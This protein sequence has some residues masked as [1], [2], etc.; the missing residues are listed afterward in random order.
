MQNNWREYTLDDLCFKITDGSHQSPKAFEG[1]IPMYSVKD[2]NDHG[3][4]RSG[5]K[6]I[7]EQDYAKLLAQGCQPEVSDILIAKDGSVM[8][9]V[10]KVDTIEKC[11]LLSS[12]AILRPKTDLVDPDFLVFSILNP[13]V[14]NNILS[15]YVSGSGVPRIVLKDFKKVVVRVPNLAIQKDI[16]KVI[17][18][19]NQKI[20]LN[21]QTNQTLEQ[22]AQ[23]L[24][25]SWFVDFD[26]VIDN[27]L[28]AGKHIPVAL[29]HKAEQRKQ[30]LKSSEF[31]PLPDD[32]R[33]LFPSEFEQTDEP[34][35]GIEGW[36]PKGWKSKAVSEAININPRVS[37]PKGTVA[38]FAD[39]KAVPTS[40]YMI[41]DV[42]EKEFKGGAKFQKYDVILARITP[43]LEN[44]KTALVD[45]LQD[46]EVG[47]G[48]T[49]FIVL[50]E[51]GAVNYPFIACLARDDNFRQ[52]CIQN[53]V[54]SSGRQRVQNSCFDFYHLALPENERILNIFNELTKPSFDK[55]I[56]NKDE[57]NTLSKLRD[58]LLPKLTSGV[59]RLKSE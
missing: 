25:K 22:M 16:A 56:I 59:I 5:A 28:A 11:A 43:C 45:F 40:G 1:G 18:N 46:N 42:I 47:F 23:A 6:T 13:I 51:N 10:F 14:K 57:I 20:L 4:N 2:M 48:S 39:M 7:S 52:H 54:G 29:Q 9:H 55:M 21:K 36:I 27:A 31:K 38:K 49:E 37:L 33:A 15:N 17:L 30:A 50:R 41:N 44:G 8:K 35:V 3:F 32:I 26:P 19:Q 58:T 53:M 12:I 34:N 24:F